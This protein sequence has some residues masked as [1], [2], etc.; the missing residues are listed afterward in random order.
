LR[1]RLAVRDGASLHVMQQCVWLCLF[2]LNMLALHNLT[3]RPAAMWSVQ[4]LEA[5]LA[6]GWRLGLY[7]C[8][9]MLPPAWQL[10]ASSLTTAA[11]LALL[12]VASW[13][14]GFD[15]LGAYPAHAAQP[16]QCA[17][18]WSVV[19]TRAF[20]LLA[21][22]AIAGCV[23]LPVF[24]SCCVS[25]CHGATQLRCSGGSA[26]AARSCICRGLHRHLRQRLAAA[27][28][29]AC[30]S[31]GANA[32]VST[33]VTSPPSC[34]QLQRISALVAVSKRAGATTPR[35][36]SLYRSPLQHTTLFVTV[37]CE[38]QRFAS[39][40]LRACLEG[41]VA[42][43]LQRTAAGH[44]SAQ[45]ATIVLSSVHLLCTVQATALVA[46]APLP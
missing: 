19:C 30:S 4:S 25:V 13:P 12:A 44:A 37:A 31:C 32:S 23:V 24:A 10:L 39:S 40:D 36:P 45:G 35:H 5:T 6:S 46:D 41:A 20:L 11:S 14:Y 16:L 33:P 34:L 22:K 17:A 9:L 1:R 15:G 27:G 21:S 18:L 26:A 2:A 38:E 43:A 42:Q 3:P 28:A 8:A 29:P 7:S